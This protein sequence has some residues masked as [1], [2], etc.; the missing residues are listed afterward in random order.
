MSAISRTEAFGALRFG[1]WRKSGEFW[2]AKLRASCSS[3]RQKPTVRKTLT[4]ATT[5]MR[6]ALVG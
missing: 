3:H 1:D 6:R 2:E 4:V 5:S